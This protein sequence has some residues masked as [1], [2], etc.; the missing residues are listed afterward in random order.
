MDPK[1]RRTPR[2]KSPLPVRVGGSR[3][4]RREATETMPDLVTEQSE[5]KSYPSGGNLVGSPI[6]D[7]NKLRSV[8]EDNFGASPRPVK[9]DQAGV[10]MLSWDKESSDM[11]VS[12]EVRRLRTVFEKD[13]NFA[14]D[15]QTL[16]A[17]DFPKPERQIKRTL[18]EFIMKYEGHKRSLCIIYYA[19]HGWGDETPGKLFIAGLTVSRDTSQPASERG[20][21]KIAWHTVEHSLMEMEADLLLIFDCCYAGALNRESRGPG[22]SF[23]FLGA[24]DYNE[25]TQKPGPA[26]FTSALI[27]ALQKLKDGVGFDSAELRR[28][29]RSMKGFPKGKQQPVLFDRFKRN[30]EHV[31]IAPLRDSTDVMEETSERTEEVS[32]A[33]EYVDLRF[34]FS[35]PQDADA[36]AK[37]AKGLN[38][39][40]HRNH[41]NSL[42]LGR[43]TFMK[44]GSLHQQVQQAAQRWLFIT[45]RSAIAEKVHQQRLS[46][47]LKSPPESDGEKA[48]EAVEEATP[49]ERSSKRRRT[50]SD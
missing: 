29:I 23:E 6:A 1:G 5:T 24:C 45:R 47:G 12:D 9:Y 39:V 7:N 11:D 34:H 17:T 49:Q 41:Y 14:V 50:D 40:A 46:R 16:K 13:Y 38:A 21:N 48:D 18:E 30:A 37:L 31:W 44:K 19:G 36:V 28:T 2:S 8:F 15:H 20:Y 10:L 22:H 25:K 35:K 26:S 42:G 27:S 43:V 32:V 3:E 4:G 33:R